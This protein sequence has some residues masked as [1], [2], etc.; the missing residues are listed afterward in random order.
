MISFKLR[1]TL[2]RFNK[3]MARSP[4]RRSQPTASA[5]N[6]VSST[7]IFK[8]M[9]AVQQSE[10][11]D[12][13]PRKL[14]KL[15]C[16]TNRYVNSIFWVYLSPVKYWFYQIKNIYDFLVSELEKRHDEKTRILKLYLHR[17]FA[18]ALNEFCPFY[19][20][21]MRDGTVSMGKKRN[22]MQRAKSEL[23]GWRI[24]MQ[25]GLLPPSTSFSRLYSES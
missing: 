21:S 18:D 10:I 22:S 19:P 23:L 24:F 8:T 3:I 2:C 20:A 6:P 25:S 17:K 11:S 13:K 15:I 14:K 4:V 1:D 16:S 9:Y 7:S 5:T 12:R